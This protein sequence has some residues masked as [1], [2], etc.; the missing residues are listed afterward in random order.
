M[1]PEHPHAVAPLPQ[2][3]IDQA[4]GRMARNILSAGALG[5]ATLIG[6]VGYAMHESHAAGDPTVVEQAYAHGDITRDEGEAQI[7]K[8]QAAQADADTWRVVGW[9]VGPGIAVAGAAGA[10]SRAQRT[11][12]KAGGGL[13]SQPLSN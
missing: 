3:V 2:A 12:K 13:S 5:I 10:I 4:Y 1:T 8:I 11:L 7:A 6:S 9:T